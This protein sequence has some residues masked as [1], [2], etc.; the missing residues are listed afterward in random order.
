MKALILNNPGEF[1]WINLASPS[2]LSI[3]QALVKI[4]AIGICGTDL[5]AFKGNQP[6]FSYPRVLGHELGVE[7]IAVGDASS[8]IKPG[9]KA[10]VE[11]YIN[12]GACHACQI[13][14]T[15]CCENLKVLGVHT[16]GGMCDFLVVPTDKLHVSKLLTHEKLALVETL[17]IGCHAVNRSAINPNQK[18]LVI[19]A[20][21]IGLTVLTFLKQ[22]GINASV[23]DLNQH[24]LDFCS[25]KNL[26]D[27]VFNA[28]NLPPM[29][30]FDVVFDATGS[31]ASMHKAIE[32]VAF[33]G[34]L[35]FVGLFQG[36]Y[37]F[38][39]PLFHRKEL[40]IMSSRNSQPTDFKSIIA[41]LE[42]DKIDINDWISVH[43]KAE[44][45]IT[46]FPL[47]YSNAQLIKAIIQ[48]S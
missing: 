19:G 9:D 36:D 5:H 32:Y 31:S 45:L 44:N 10:A 17:G 21:P 47:L 8:A 30:G 29:N 22:R 39:D 12:C 7:V 27:Q 1:E 11:P 41:L 3:N 15:N 23:F 35:I 42:E 33:G 13:G 43:L 40:S 6:F 38:N 37:T 26:C 34:K 25:D 46:D 24:R 48:W 28:D 16:D 20:G 14:K 2:E 18:A 4:H